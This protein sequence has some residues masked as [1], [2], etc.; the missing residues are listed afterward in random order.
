MML[1]ILLL[2]LP[3]RKFTLWTKN[4]IK[5]KE[6]YTNKRADYTI[7]DMRYN[8]KTMKINNTG[9]TFFKSAFIFHFNFNFV[10]VVSF[11][12]SWHI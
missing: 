4:E 6:K 1:T 7:C 10:H 11:V 3:N 5:K 12:Y 2:E 8:M 9:K